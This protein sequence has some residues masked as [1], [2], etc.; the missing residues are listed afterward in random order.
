MNYENILYLPTSND[1]DSIIINKVL[2]SG[3]VSKE[4]WTTVSNG[5]R[6]AMNHEFILYFKE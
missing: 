2:T 6:I 5:R 1:E 3:I 4:N